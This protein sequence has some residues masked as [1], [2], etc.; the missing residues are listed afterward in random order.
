MNQIVLVLVVV[1][2]Y[3]TKPSIEN[4]DV[5]EDVNDDGDE[6]AVHEMVAGLI[7]QSN[8]RNVESGERNEKTNHRHLKTPSRLE[9][10]SV[11]TWGGERP[12]SGSHRAF[13]G[14]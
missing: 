3:E 11:Q 9:K 4:E 6:R 13:W 7:E 14:R 12:S 2:A 1:L 10:S 8:S 5:N